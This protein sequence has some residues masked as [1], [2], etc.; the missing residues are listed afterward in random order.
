LTFQVPAGESYE[1]YLLSR[2]VDWAGA[3][4][5]NPSTAGH[6]YRVPDALALPGD[7]VY[8]AVLK[9]AASITGVEP[10]IIEALAM[11]YSEYANHPTDAAF[12]E[13]GGGAQRAWNVDEWVWSMIG[14]SAMC[15]YIPKKGGG[16]AGMSMSHFPEY[17]SINTSGGNTPSVSVAAADPVGIANISIELSAW[18]H[19]VLA[20][21]D[22]RKS[23][24]FLADLNYQFPGAG[25]TAADLPL[26]VDVIIHTNM[27]NLHTNP[28]VSK[29][30][31]AYKKVPTFI[32]ID[33]VMTPTARMADI[34]FP[35]ATHLEKESYAVPSLTT[36][37]TFIHRDKII[38]RMYDTL[39]E[40][41]IQAM[42]TV[43]L[44]TRLGL[45]EAVLDMWLL[46]VLGIPPFDVFSKETYEVTRITD[47]YKTNV[48]DID[49]PTAEELKNREDGLFL[50]ET[51]KDRV[52]LPMSDFI[53]PGAL[54]TSTG[55]LNFYSPLRAMRP[56]APVSAGAT[57]SFLYYPGGWRNATLSYQPIMQ[58]R[59]FYFDDADT[60]TGTLGNPL[61]GRFVGFSSPISGRS[62]A[63]QY[64]TNKSRNRGHTVFDGVAAIKDHFPQVVKMNPADAGAR[65]IRDGDMVYVYND[66]G[67]MKIPASLTH[68]I[69]PGVI[70]V[71][72]GG[73]YRPHPTE[74]VKVWM[75]ID[76]TEAFQE[77]SVPVDVGG[78]DNILTNDFFGEDTLWCSGAV[79]AQTGPCEVSLTKPENGGTEI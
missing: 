1:E 66:R 31:A 53:V 58:G 56:A 3:T 62:Y 40:Q 68:A 48:Q 67:C 26:E 18:Q 24:N 45:P 75:Q 9:Y 29:N 37:T 6:K 44:C 2:E 16:I 77:V 19:L 73:W 11:K 47:Y 50:L 49:L 8:T 25:F 21:K 71:E 60:S 41:E 28:N 57:A 23:A 65:G 78:A 22:H 5:V 54:E 10:N 64:M 17:L 46:Y 36:G 55:F 27:N 13:T 34:I 74:K 63:L 69:L 42:L 30:A 51:S 70:S 52:M 33:Q 14:L 59:E 32:A 4:A 43:K 15:G 72:H 7:S 12:I 39:S 38:D 35:A 20:G 76:A 79:P 61:T